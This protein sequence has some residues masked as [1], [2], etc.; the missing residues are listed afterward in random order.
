M[1]KTFYGSLAVNNIKKNARSYIPY[2][3]TCTVC[4]MI[5]YIMMAIVYNPDVTK[6]FGGMTLKSMLGFGAWI[7]GFFSAI[8]LFYTNSFLIKQRKKELALYNILGMAKRHIGRVFFL[9]TFLTSAV[10][11]IVGLL[12]GII[13]GKLVFLLLL[14]LLGV[15]LPMEYGISF[16]AIIVTVVLFGIIFCAVLLCNMGR[17][18]LSNPMELLA[19]SRQGE[20][21]PKTKWI[22]TILGFLFT[23]VGYY[24]AITVESPIDAL[25]AFF[26]AVILV[27]AGTYLLFITGSIAILKMLRKN[28]SFYYKTSHFTAIS[29][30]LYR[31]KRNAAGLASICILSTMVLVTV[32]TTVSLQVGCDDVVQRN[33]PNDIQIESI[34][35]QAMTRDEVKQ[36]QQ[37]VLD[38][39][40]AHD[41]IATY[42]RDYD[43]LATT[44]TV[45]ENQF[46]LSQLY[47]LEAGSGQMFF[48][49]LA[50]SSLGEDYGPLAKDQVIVAGDREIPGDRIHV[51]SLEFDLKDGASDFKGVPT[52][53][54]MV[55]NY[56]ILV[57]DHDVQKQIMKEAGGELFVRHHLI[58]IDIDPDDWDTV[59]DAMEELK[60]KKL[61]AGFFIQNRQQTSADF[62]SI[63]G[64]LLFVGIFLGILFLLATVLIIYYKQITEGYEDSDRYQIMQKVG[65]SLTEVKRSIRSQILLVF[66]L[67]L[68]VAVCHVAA[69]FNMMSK[70]LLA[71]QIPNIGLFAASTGITL[72]VFVVIYVAVY[73][74]TA[75]EYYKLVK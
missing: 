13:F 19:G 27:I 59:P 25:L 28:K 33:F 65:M 39:L 36:V 62:H 52:M 15:T 10:S 17:I 41:I 9:E 7:V 44:G 67:P 49:S 70:L 40:K 1:N 42:M 48:I 6:M 56:Y 16:D 32:S 46:N 73:S 26:I 23:G 30:M 22:L 37:K 43:Y 11:L 71:L 55:S 35:D 63:Y 68:A 66:F 29:G 74:L 8:F 2:M 34:G 57:S 3:L 12:S 38:T 64:G 50:D 47:S 58:G 72:L 31:M 61:G 20:K 54:S 45:K 75:R 18:R 14:K 53:G 69:A 24:I 60:T 21:E 5:F 4:I 51:G